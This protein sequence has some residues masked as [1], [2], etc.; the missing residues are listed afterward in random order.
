MIGQDVDKLLAKALSESTYLDRLVASPREAAA[1]IGVTL[2]D[3]E[4]AT[5]RAMTP[6]DVRAFA[7]DYRAQ[8]D[9]DKRRA[10]C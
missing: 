3:D 7:A 8:T 4:V 2:G 6:D 1:E 9:P 10:A 5:F